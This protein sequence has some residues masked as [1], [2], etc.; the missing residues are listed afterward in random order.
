MNKIILQGNPL[1]TNSLYRSIGLGR[2]IISKAGRALK[3]NYQ[4]QAKS[5]L[6][7]KQPIKEGLNLHIF[8]FF[9]DKRKRDIDN[10]GKIL[11]DSLSGI[12]YIDDSQIQVMTVVKNY[13]KENPRIEILF[14]PAAST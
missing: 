8:L 14:T 1:S 11:L 7:I 2:V 3:T 10:Y 6:K 9:G 12:L 13:C 5:Q 4:W